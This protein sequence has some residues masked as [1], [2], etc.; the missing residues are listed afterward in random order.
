MRCSVLQVGSGGPGFGAFGIVPG[1]GGDIYTDFFGPGCE[2]LLIDRT[3]FAGADGLEVEA[4]D[5]YHADG[6]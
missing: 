4:G 3:G 6:G 1:L 2:K 5:G